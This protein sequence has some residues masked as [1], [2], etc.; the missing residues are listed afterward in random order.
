M[1]V[2]AGQLIFTVRSSTM[3]SRPHE[4]I[5]SGNM[6]YFRWTWPLDKTKP[7]LLSSGTN[8]AILPPRK[9][10]PLS[11]GWF[12]LPLTMQNR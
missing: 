10:E 3:H 11:L 7:S 9:L 5:P 8:I 2:F 12:V 1:A 4:I 6:C